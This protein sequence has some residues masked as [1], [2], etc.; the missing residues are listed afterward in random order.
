[1]PDKASL[2]PLRALTLASNPLL[3]ARY[4]LEPAQGFNLILEL[5]HAIHGIEHYEVGVEL[6]PAISRCCPP[7]R[8]RVLHAQPA[9]NAE[10]F[11]VASVVAYFLS[12]HRELLPG[13][14]IRRDDR[15]PA[16]AEPGG[17][18]DDGVR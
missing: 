12:Q 11:R 1:M 8:V 2:P 9:L 14:L 15:H 7:L 5:R 16:V 6:T 4:F 10:I 3:A 13:L 18:F 17:A